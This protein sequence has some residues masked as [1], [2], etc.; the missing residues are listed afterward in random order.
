MLRIAHKTT[1]RAAALALVLLAAAT[2]SDSGPRTRPTSPESSKGAAD[3]LVSRLMSDDPAVRKAA[4]SR[5]TLMRAQA[6]PLLV[7]HL[8][9]RDTRLVRSIQDVLQ[10]IE[11]T[12][13]EAAEGLRLSASPAG[14]PL[15]KGQAIALW[16]TVRNTTRSDIFVLPWVMDLAARPPGDAGAAFEEKADHPKLTRLWAP[17]GKTPGRKLEPGQSFGFLMDADPSD[18]AAA[19]MKIAAHLK[20]Y[21]CKPADV[22]DDDDD[23]ADF[24]DAMRPFDVEPFELVLAPI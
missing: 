21:Q 18:S 11:G 4:E 15:A 19:P 8:H 20:I 2:K 23:D 14:P 24:P 13:G 9:D 3:R 7:K 10:N 6:V 1:M 22:D 12:P 17:K 5:L 16:L